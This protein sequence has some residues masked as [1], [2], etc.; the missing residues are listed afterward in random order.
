MFTTGSEVI[1]I[2]GPPAVPMGIPETF[3]CRSMNIP[4]TIQWKLYYTSV[5]GSPLSVSTLSR[6]IMNLISTVVN[7]IE[8]NESTSQL[9]P[10]TTNRNITSI[11]CNVRDNISDM[12]RVSSINVTVYGKCC[13]FYWFIV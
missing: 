3:T 8:I 6:D 7:I 2:M 13:L 1:H 12:L 5:S 10:N 9:V 11:D 4:R